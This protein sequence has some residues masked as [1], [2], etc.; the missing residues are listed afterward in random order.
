ME[1]FD[2]YEILEVNR[3]ASGEEIKK[4]YRKMAL[5]YHPDR[6]PDNENAEEMFKKVNEAYQI[7][8]DKEKRQIY[9][10]YGK[11][12]LE[13]SGFGFGDMEGSIF[14][15]FNSVFGGGFGGFGS[16]R[17]KDEK[18]SRDLAIELELSFQ[19]AIF[20]CKKEVEI[21]YKSACS[22]CK[23]DRKSVV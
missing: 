9:D 8:S 17:K 20:G 12:G 21:R 3:T 14:D 7:L 2:Y 19:E 10:T 22:A 13:S 5:K 11:K 16:R 15:I 23:G 4:A 1:E 18:Y 6:N